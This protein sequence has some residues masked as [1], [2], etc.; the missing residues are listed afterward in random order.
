[1]LKWFFIFLNCS[2]RAKEMV[3]QVEVLS[4]SPENLRSN[5]GDHM[6]EGEC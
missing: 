1:M 3:Q 6:R 4:V 2:L 5:S